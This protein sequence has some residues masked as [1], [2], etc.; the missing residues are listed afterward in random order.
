VAKGISKKELKQPDE[1]VSFWTHAAERAQRFAAERRRALLIG[2]TMLV[3]VVVGSVIVSNISESRAKKAS[4]ELARIE[5][6]AAADLR[7]DGAPATNPDGTPKPDDGVPHF[8]TDKERAEAALKQLDAF[9]ASSGNPLRTEGRLERGPLLLALGRAPEAI[10]SYE[11][12][13]SGRLDDRLRFLAHEGLGYAQ[14]QKG[15][16]AAALAS[17]EKLTE[18]AAVFKEGGFFKERAAYHKARIAE[19]RGNAED[20]KKLYKEVLDR[21]PTSSLRDEITNRLAVLELK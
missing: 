1:F 9:V 6:L 15:D 19:L 3:T 2:S 13:L 8:K 21:N 20:A 18:D 17:F 16:L 5:R 11:E 4:E 14:E 10:S 12:I 7:P